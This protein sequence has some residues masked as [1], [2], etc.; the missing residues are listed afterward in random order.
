[1]L[2]SVSPLIAPPSCI[3]GDDLYFSDS[4]NAC[5]RKV[6][7]STGIVSDV[8]GVCGSP[9][10]GDRAAAA[11]QFA[12]GGPRGLE[13]V[14]TDLWIA[15]SGNRVIRVL[16]TANGSVVTA[17]GNFSLGGTSVS[18][19]TAL[20]AGF[21]LPTGLAFRPES[22]E[23][24]GRGRAMPIGPIA[25]SLASPPLAILICSLLQRRRCL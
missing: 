7:I 18:D 15:D 17:A 4:G 3:S 10:Y 1:M 25:P 9:G 8:A 23:V 21:V 14:G 6:A 2:A 24:K 16:S 20:S 5:V 19:G 12:S 11:A 13:F 22:N